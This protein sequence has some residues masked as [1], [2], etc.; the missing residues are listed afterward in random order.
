M[1]RLSVIMPAY[2]EAETISTSIERVLAVGVATQLIV[3]DDGSSDGTRERLA[4]I[5]HPDVL[6]LAHP[7]NRGK[8]AAIRTALARATGD[9]VVI[10]DADLEYDPADLE[11]MLEPFADASVIAV[12][13]SRY[14]R[15]DKYLFGLYWVLDKLLAWPGSEGGALLVDRRR[16]LGSLKRGLTPMDSDGSA[17]TREWFDTVKLSNFY[18]VML[19][20]W[21]ANALYG[22]DLTDEATCYKA[23]R[24]DVLRALE[25]EREGFLF[26]PELTSK[27]GLGR[28]RI[29]EVSISYSPRK[30]H[31]GK[32]IRW[33]DGA[34][35]IWEL[36][37]NRF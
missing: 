16:V 3:V 20:T 14:T 27:L 12:F 35:A 4:S 17:R 9:V 36:V 26:C 31:E 28:H 13:G 33:S 23:V 34:A 29:V 24:T 22:L 10:Q 7:R 8:S 21:L 11:K 2:N 6:V 32:K 5:D 15:A 1:P 18:C 25:L 37:R 19:L 30:V